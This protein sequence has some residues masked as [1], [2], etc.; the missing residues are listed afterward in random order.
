MRSFPAFIILLGAFWVGSLAF[1]QISILVETDHER[2]VT[3]EDVNFNVTLR[4]MSGS[5]LSFGDKPGDGKILLEVFDNS[6]REVQPFP[7]VDSVGEPV[8]VSPRSLNFGLGM[9]LPNGLSKEVVIPV[10]KFFP[11]NRD[12]YYEVKV[13][14]RHPRMQYDYISKPIRISVTEGTEFY[15]T[16]VGIPSE[17]KGKIEERELVVNIFQAETEQ[18]YVVRSQDDDYVYNVVRLAPRVRGVEPMMSV[19]ARNQL[20]FMV[21]TQS[22]LFSH[23]IIDPHGLVKEEAHYIVEDG[24]MLPHLVSD[25]DIGRVMV[26]GGRRAREGIDYNDVQLP[27]MEAI[28]IQPN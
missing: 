10:N 26:V 28:E 8:R 23:W 3:H 15:K 27:V 7:A 20:H 13:R 6:H 17:R 21:Q 25:P 4:N 11:L 2:Y 16:I 24:L 19:D 5:A 14:V 1:G 18:L 12:G 9:T 22:R